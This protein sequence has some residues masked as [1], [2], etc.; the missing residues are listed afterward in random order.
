MWSRSTIYDFYFPGLSQIGEQAVLNKEI[1]QDNSANDELVF[2]Y[3]EAY[4][5][6][7][8]KTSKITGAFRS[9]A[10]APLDS[11]HLSEEFSSLP[12]LNSTFITSTTPLDRC[13]AVPA[14]PHFILDVF[15]NLK[16]VRPMPIHG[17]PGIAK[18]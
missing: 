2:G 17:V 9:S 13:I 4:S 8:F 3:Q 5:D 6:Y 15:F 14:E 11:W 12:G 18:F 7:R 10:A 16:S 1:Y